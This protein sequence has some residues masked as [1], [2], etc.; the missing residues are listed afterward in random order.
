MPEPFREGVQSQ[1]TVGELAVLSGMILTL[2]TWPV[3][4]KIWRRTSSVT[5]GSRPPT[6]NALLFGSGAARRGV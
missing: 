4:S 1:L 2:W 5:R 3:V 6:Y